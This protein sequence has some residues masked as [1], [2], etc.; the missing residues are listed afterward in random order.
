MDT[1]AAGVTQLR[2]QRFMSV[3]F[4]GTGTP[5]E[6]VLADTGLLG[7]EKTIRAAEDLYGPEVGPQAIVLTHGHLDRLG[8][9][10]A[11]ATGWHDRC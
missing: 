7:S 3:Y 4:V 1:V 10:L 2:I 11:L 5:G 9:A 6:W 8:P